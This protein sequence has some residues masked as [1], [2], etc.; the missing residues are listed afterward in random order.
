MALNFVKKVLS[1][2]GEKSPKNPD[3]TSTPIPENILAFRT[4]T[5]LLSQIPRTAKLER[6]D[7]LEGGRKGSLSRHILRISDA[8]AHI[9]ASEHDV[10]A[11]TTNH[12]VLSVNLKVLA[13]VTAESVPESLP[14]T[15][16]NGFARSLFFMWTANPPQTKLPR[17]TPYPTIISPSPPDDLHPETAFD[18][19]SALE[20]NWN[21][22]SLHE[23]LWILCKMLNE[24]P[25]DLNYK[26][27]RNTAAMHYKKIAHRFNN[28]T[29]SKPYLDSLK[30]VKVIPFLSQ[31]GKQATDELACVI[32]SNDLTLQLL[33]ATRAILALR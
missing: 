18:Y 4:I 13:A 2:K 28:E 20:E 3:V 5:T 22:P 12:A 25:V 32:R 15:P 7:Y 17:E 14:S 6:I 11:V 26:L 33:F 10:V 29:L 16:P 19:I 24:K 31:D 23:H 27:S 30:R 8:F 21:P 9:A 1:G